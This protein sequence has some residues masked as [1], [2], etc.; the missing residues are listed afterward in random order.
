MLLIVVLAVLVLIFLGDI[1]EM[2]GYWIGSIK[3]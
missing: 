1:A 2:L 3:K